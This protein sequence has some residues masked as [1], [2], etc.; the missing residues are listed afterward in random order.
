MNDSSVLGGTGG[1]ESSESLSSKLSPGI[2]SA[3]SYLFLATMSLGDIGF[4]VIGKWS[5]QAEIMS[6]TSLTLFPLMGIS[7]ISRSSSPVT[8][9]QT[10]S[11]Y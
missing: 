7:L 2:G 11:H 1:G 3:T 8:E 5:G 6:R 10:K 4:R 9:K